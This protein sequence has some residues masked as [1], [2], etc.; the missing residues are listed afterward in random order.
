[1]KPVDCPCLL[2]LAA[3]I[4]MASGSFSSAGALTQD[5]CKWCLRQLRNPERFTNIHYTAQCAANRL[6][7]L[8]LKA[9]CIQAKKPN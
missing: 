2:I 8:L 7:E 6:E 1:M 5:E 3:L 9:R 4:A